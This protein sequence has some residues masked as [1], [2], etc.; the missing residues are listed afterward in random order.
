MLRRLFASTSRIARFLFVRCDSRFLRL[1]TP[2]TRPPPPS[3]PPPSIALGLQSHKLKLNVDKIQNASRFAIKSFVCPLGG[4]RDNQRA[5]S[6]SGRPAGTREGEKGHGIKLYKECGTDLITGGINS[7]SA[8]G[9]CFLP[10]P[11]LPF[12]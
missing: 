8:N 7:A 10:F 11:F 3:P 4:S 5:S 12:L 1:S 9:F 2:F 6:R